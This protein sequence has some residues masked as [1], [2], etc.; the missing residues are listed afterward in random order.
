MS[1]RFFGFTVFVFA[2]VLIP[3]A[4]RAQ[5]DASVHGIVI[6]AAD[7]S[8]VGAARLTLRTRASG[9]DTFVESDATGHFTFPTVAP[10]EQLLTTDAGGFAAQEIALQLDPREIRFLVVR[11]AIQPVTASVE[12][13]AAPA[14]LPGTHS[15]SSST[16]TS[17]RIEALPLGIRTTLPDAMA[18]SAPGMIKGHDDF[19]HVRGQELG[20]YP[21]INGITFWENPH[22][23][24][25]ASLNP[26]IIDTVNVMTGG[27]PAEYGNRFGG[28]LDLVTKSGWSMN[29][30][31]R[32]T[33]GG[34]SAG[35]VNGSAD[36]GNH[37]S[38]FAYYVGG[39]WSRSDRFLSPPESKA[40][41]D[42]GSAQHGIVQLDFLPA[43][44]QTF[45]VLFMGDRA[46]FDIPKTELDATLRPGANASQRH[47]QQTAIA[48]WRRASVEGAAWSVS[49]Y[50]R[51]SESRLSP[52][53]HPLAAYGQYDRS[54]LTVGA[55]TTYDRLTRRHAIRAGGDAVHLRPS[56][57]LDYRYG[58]FRD[59]S[60]LIGMGHFHF[61]GDVLVD[62]DE[63]GGA[64]SA[65]VQDLVQVNEH[66]TLD[67]GA[68]VD[69]YD[70][71][72]ARTHGSPRVNA[73]YR[74]GDGRTV[75]H[76]SYNHLFSPPP[77]EGLLVSSAGLTATIRE[78][79]RALPPLVPTTENQAEL[80][81]TR[82]LSRSLTAS[83]TG[84]G[85]ASRNPV[86]ST[87]WPDSRIYSYTSFDRARSYGLE[88]KAE[89]LP[90]DTRP[91]SAWVNYALGRAWFYGPVTGGFIPDPHELEHTGRFLAPMD[92]THT[93]TAG[94]R[95]AH[96]PSRSRIDIA[97]LYGSGTPVHGGEEGEEHSHADAPAPITSAAEATHAEERVPGY[98]TQS[99][100]L[101]VELLPR[102]LDLEASV[103][104]LTNRPYALAA[105]SVFSPSQFSAPRLFS[106]ALR[107]KF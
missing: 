23:V 39:S 51:R 42:A 92:Q 13:T 70:L 74:L 48:T 50:E 12:V 61:S 66:L 79:G 44:R 47:M 63:R 33:A 59:L 25:S 16:I 11:L 7:G 40:I 71:V 6:A 46:E 106:A 53:V 98:F 15:P 9:R 35:R 78:I 81:I 104:N 21:A 58:G 90:A 69:R 2:A 75:V 60:H 100:T 65:F 93:L 36:Y 72:V 97:L 22:T 29:G 10:G 67:V 1:S 31:G 4:A 38:T 54:L 3:A 45:Q 41:H 102:R 28:V 18:S 24:F 19:V 76:A 101:T 27:F 32:V 8:P 84:Y 57:R 83:I 88:A 64:A 55:K 96:A 94:A 89:L 68:R 49:A 62:L 5:S 77:I 85:R 14:A 87:V 95:F 73:A 86:H 30:T 107:W 82:T 17:Q 103:E 105:E 52:A 37:T 43:E 34:G 20:L 26:D 80:G 56:E 99:V 91:Y